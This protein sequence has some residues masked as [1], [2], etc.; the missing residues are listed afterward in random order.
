MYILDR[1]LRVDEGYP[2]QAMFLHGTSLRSRACYAEHF[3]ASTVL[4]GEVEL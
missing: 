2:W 1:Q 3:S 4:L